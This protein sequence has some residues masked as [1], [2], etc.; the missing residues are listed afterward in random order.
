MTVLLDVSASVT[1]SV[2]DE[3]RRALKQLRADLGAQDRLRLMTFNMRVQ[4]LVDFTDP[5]AK[6]DTALASARRQRQ[7]RRLRQPR[8]RALERRAARA[9]AN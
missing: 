7:Q 9:G 1:G 5:A 3:L 4:R 8:R 6:I 2:L